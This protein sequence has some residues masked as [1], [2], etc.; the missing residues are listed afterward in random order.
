MYKAGQQFR[1]WEDTTRRHWSQ[2][3]ARPLSTVIWYPAD[4]SAQ[5]ADELL[6]A[7]ESLFLLRGVAHDA[8]LRASPQAFPVVLLSHGTGGSALQL[9]WLGR[10]LAARG[11]VVAAVNHHGNTSREPYLPHGFLLW[12]ERAKD[13]TA[14]PVHVVVTEGDAETPPRLNGCRYAQLIANAE[15]T[16]IEGPAGHYVFLA[17]ATAAGRKA[18]PELCA[19]D[20]TVDRRALHERVASL[21]GSF[22]DEVLVNGPA[23]QSARA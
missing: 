5:E 10:A 3:G 18:L 8:P 11:Y 4:D 2:P 19:D 20:P 15:L 9:G 22:F 17:E 12:W 13:L 6:G 21:A 16:H 14:V 23:N 1:A 7:P